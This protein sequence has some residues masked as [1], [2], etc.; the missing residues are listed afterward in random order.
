MA[1]TKLPAGPTELT[2]DWLTGALRETGVISDASVTGLDYEII[3]EG[4]GVLGQLARFNLTYDKPEDGAPNS[5]VGKFPAATQENRDLANLFRFYEREVRFYEQIADEVELRT[6]RRYYSHFDDETNDFMLLME[7]LGRAPRGGHNNPE[8]GAVSR[9]LVEQ[10]GHTA[11]G[12]DPLWQ[13]SDQP[14]RRV[15]I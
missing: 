8:Y 1:K 4:V 9:H 7:D 15:F 12:L 2:A 10:S 5:L 6:P 3:G 13:R 11:V 14:F